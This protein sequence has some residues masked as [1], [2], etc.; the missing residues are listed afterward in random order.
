MKPQKTDQIQQATNLQKKLEDYLNANNQELSNDKKQAV[1]NSFLSG[2]YSDL[3]GVTA[4]RGFIY[5]YYVTVKYLVDMV[6][7]RF[8]WWDKVIF[9]LLD[10][11][12]L[13]G[14][15][16]IRF[17]QVKT[18]GDSNLANYLKPSDLYQRTKKKGSWLDKLFLLNVHIFDIEH[19]S[20][21]TD[22]ALIDQHEL[23]FELATNAQYN[24]NISIYEK[25]D[26]FRNDRDEDK[27]E[28]LIS[29]MEM[30]NLSWE[31]SFRGNTFTFNSESYKEPFKNPNWYLKR[32]RIQ[33]YGV[34]ETLREE[35]LRTIMSNTS[36]NHDAFHQYK[37]NL[38]FDLILGEV[39][40]RTCQDGDNIDYKN[41]VFDK[42]TFQQQLDQWVSQADHSALEASTRNSLNGKFETCFER[43]HRDF[44]EEAWSSSLKHELL[45]TLSNIQDQF[46]KQ[47]HE[48]ADPYAYQR[49]LQR[50]FFRI[51]SQSRIPMDVHDHE[52]RLYK[53]L[54]YI[55]YC[56]VFY[57]KSSPSPK[58][59][60]VIFK[61]GF[62]DMDQKKIFSIYN[63]REKEDFEVAM[64]AVRVSSLNCS[65]SQTMVHDYN[66]FIADYIEKGVK[67]KSRKRRGLD[68]VHTS[69]TQPIQEDEM[70]DQGIEITRQTENIKFYPINFIKDHFLYL[71][72]DEPPTLSFREEEVIEQWH[73]ELLKKHVNSMEDK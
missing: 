21:V 54:K 73:E 39:I 18:L 3:S 9:E 35:I 12:A 49:F 47:V 17:V 45:V 22:N 25:D 46:S 36:G 72:Y 7:S 37:A 19:K 51:N 28:D 23:Q 10:D 2:K 33:R 61:G 56:L 60:S 57:N 8:A 68:S 64:K 55:I 4:I 58:E 5:Q 53:A 27:D 43:I 32:F 15:G 42:D 14:N 16:K 52:H 66:C 11:I 41:F 69:I 40:K 48:G 67:T 6:F 20:I 71:L 62:T 24:S 1:I 26:Y 44:Q 13:Y 29:K 38:V 50:L 65:V 34:I 30:N 59:A 70:K 31:V 63:A